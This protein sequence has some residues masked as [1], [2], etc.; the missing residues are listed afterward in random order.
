MYFPFIYAL[1]IFFLINNL[2]GMVPYSFAS[3]SRFILTFFI[4]FTVVL[5]ATILGFRSRL[6]SLFLGLL[7][8][9]C[10]LF[11][12]IINNNYKTMLQLILFLITYFQLLDI[13]TYISQL[14]ELYQTITGLSSDMPSY[15]NFITIDN[16]NS[17]TDGQTSDATDYI[18]PNYWNKCSRCAGQGIE[19]YVQPG[20]HC[21]RCSQAC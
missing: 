9:Y 4:S 14:I 13:N 16:I 2:I 17:M 15:S 7:F 5:G 11:T 20:K 3:T 1:F 18:K 10:L 6:I 19:V 21:S 8:F 12:R